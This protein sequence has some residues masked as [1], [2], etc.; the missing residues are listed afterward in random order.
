MQTPSLSATFL[1]SPTSNSY[2][3]AE[4]SGDI[5]LHPADATQRILIGNQS[6]APAMLVLSSNDAVISGNL[7]S[8]NISTNTVKSTGIMLMMGD[9]SIDSS[10]P[11]YQMLGLNAALMGCNISMSTSNLAHN[12]GTLLTSNMYG[13]PT[14]NAVVGVAF[15][16]DAYFR[17]NVSVLGN[18]AC[19]GSITTANGTSV[20]PATSNQAFKLY[21]ATG[22]SNVFSSAASFQSNVTI[23][24]HLLPSSSHVQNIGSSNNRF[25]AA[26]VDELHIATNTLYLGDTPVLG[27]TD[28]TVMV[29]ADVD[30]SINVTTKGLGYT[31]LSSERGVNVTT[32]GLN[33]VVDIS[34]T[35]NGG[36]I[37]FGA[38]SQITFTAPEARFNGAMTT[39]NMTVTGDLTVTGTRFITNAQTVEVKDNVIVINSGELGYGVSSQDSLAGIRVS[40]GQYPSYD[41]VFDETDDMFKVGLSGQLETLAS[42]PWVTSKSSNAVMMGTVTLSNSLFGATVLSSSNDGA[43]VCGGNV[44]CSNAIYVGGASNAL[45]RSGVDNM[46]RLKVGGIDVGTFNSNSISLLTSAIGGF[47][48]IGTVT[49][50]C[51]LDVY[52]VQGLNTF[53]R[54]GGNG[55]AGAKAGLNM[56]PR[57]AREGGPSTQVAALDDGQNSAHILFSTAAP[58]LAS[59]TLSERMRLTSSGLLGV[60][61]NAPAYP[62]HVTSHVNNVSLY[63]LYDITAFSDARVKTDLQRIEGALD[64]VTQLTGY[65]YRRTDEGS[66]DI[67]QCGVIA[68]QVQRVLPEAVHVHPDTGMLSV[69]YGN[70]VSLVIEAI[71]E[72]KQDLDRLKASFEGRAPPS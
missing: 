23:S 37:K 3:I 34:S 39:S 13:E 40:R 52:N 28:N 10:Y 64:K 72:I 27:T 15:C 33:A 1:V 38:T 60:G 53:I 61:T 55:Q 21:T 14:S 9:Q 25:G 20:D 59:T 50:A 12:I 62:V 51:A 26:W 56:S 43:L 4:R 29:R 46:T 32:G 58:G 49:P 68:Q 5:L 16:N 42:R 19:S 48:G 2:F 70:M 30:Q 6:N 67:R 69:A 71:K 11:A 31:M 35:G 66:S 18:L 63:A 17:S 47:L 41:F 45:Y 24:G 54:V 22:G 36:E 57:V 8:T 44:F 7:T 65:T